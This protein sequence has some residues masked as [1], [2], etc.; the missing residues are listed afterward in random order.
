M[1]DNSYAKE[2][3][4]N[5]V[6]FLKPRLCSQQ[7]VAWLDLCCG[8]GRA[9][10]E[11]ARML[12][13]VRCEADLRLVGVDLVAMFYAYPPELDFLSLEETSVLKWE[14]NCSF[15]LI[16]CVHGLHYVGNKL[17]LIEKAI[18]WLKDNGSFLAHLDPANLKF[19][20][21]EAAG[22]K[23]ISELRRHGLDYNKRRHLLYCQ[24]RAEIHL[25]YEYLGADDRAGPNYTKQEAVDSY[26]RLLKDDAC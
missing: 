6:E 14:P 15:D 16:T 5:P 25:E 11:A 20:H 4:F 13:P 1:G 12:L 17:H 19:E 23:I 9:L 22:N 21:G 26:Y 3:A 2:L 18:A 8:T 24:G 10:I 7:H